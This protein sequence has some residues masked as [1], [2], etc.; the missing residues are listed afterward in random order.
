M[1]KHFFWLVP[2]SLYDKPYIYIYIYTPNCA[3]YTELKDHAL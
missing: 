2:G 1:Y 3:A